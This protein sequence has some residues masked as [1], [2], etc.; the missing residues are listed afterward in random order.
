[1]NELPLE[2][3]NQFILTKADKLNFRNFNV[4]SLGDY[5]LYTHRNLDVAISHQGDCSIVLLGDCFDFRAPTHTN[6]DIVKGLTIQCSLENLLDQLQFFSGVHLFIWKT[7]DTLLVIPD[8]CCLR[9]VFIDARKKGEVMAASSPNIINLVHP[10]KE[11]QNDFYSSEIFETRKVWVCDQTNLEGITRLKPNYL[12]DINT[13]LTN[14]FFPVIKLENQPLDTMVEKTRKIMPGILKAIHLRGKKMMIGLTGGWDSRFLLAASKEIYQDFTFFINRKES[15]GFD[16][17][18]A[19]RLADRFDLR[20]YQLRL[21]SQATNPGGKHNL[22]S[23][24]PNV[25]MDNFNSISSTVKDFSGYITISGSTSEISRNEFGPLENLNG[26]I[27]A[28]LAKY[29]NNPYCI[30]AYDKWLNENEPIYKKFGYKTLDMFYWEE[31][32]GNRVAKSL[33]EA[34]GMNVHIYPAF[35]CRFLANSFLSVD[36]KYREKQTSILYEKIIRKEWKETLDEPVNPGFKKRVIRIMQQLG[37]YKAYR[38]IFNT[39]VL[40][41]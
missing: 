20:F 14:R 23:V 41:R 17:K 35:N 28:S 32:T 9:E 22:F 38:S 7:L 29:P 21:T 3:V 2:F 27:L 10:V 18:I 4:A 33:A 15:V 16:H 6:D 37:I 11:I 5:F 1:M 8:M 34:R 24:L 39:G 12:L 30:T 36:K 31:I 25:T 26:S 19:N 13:G 40:P